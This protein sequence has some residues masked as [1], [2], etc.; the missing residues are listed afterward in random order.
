MEDALFS[1]EPNIGPAIRRIEQAGAIPSTVKTLNY[2]LRFFVARLATE[3][4][5]PDKLPGLTIPEPEK[6][7]PIDGPKW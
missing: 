1:S 6:L 3:K 7:P 5:F 4:V 2:E